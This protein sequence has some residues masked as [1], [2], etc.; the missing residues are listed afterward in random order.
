MPSRKNSTVSSC[1]F[2]LPLRR[3]EQS[4]CIQHGRPFRHTKA[5][6]Q[7]CA[8]MSFPPRG[9]AQEYWLT[10]WPPTPHPSSR[11]PCELCR[12]ACKLATIDAMVGA[13]ALGRTLPRNSRACWAFSPCAHTL[14]YESQE[15]VRGPDGVIARGEQIQERL[16]RTTVAFCTTRRG[17]CG[18][19]SWWCAGP[20]GGNDETQTRSEGFREHC[21]GGSVCHAVRAKPPRS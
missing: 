13:I 8:R 9:H 21:L 12:S 4:T 17:D 5:F 11:A 14:S 18:M 7:M 15:H 16:T 6:S 1:T 10:S 3:D 2:L 20:S 19:Y